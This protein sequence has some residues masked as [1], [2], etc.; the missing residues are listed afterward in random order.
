MS[1]YFHKQELSILRK[2]VDKAEKLIANK[3]YNK[4]E[5]INN[6]IVILEDY[7]RKHKLI[8]Y[9]GTAINNILPVED[10]FYNK[11]TEIP[12]YDFFSPN[13]IHDAKVLA[14]IYYKNGYTDVEAKAGVH[15]GTYKLFVNFIPIADITYQDPEIYDAINNEAIMVDGILYAPP[16]YL[17]MSMYL[18][19]SRPEG[20]VSRW[21]KILKRL[22][23]LNKH[24][25]MKNPK[26]NSLNFMRNFEHGY[27]KKTASIYTIVKDSLI[28]QGCV[29]FGGFAA[30]LYGKYMPKDEKKTL[31]KN[32]DFDVLAID[33][34]RS[35]IITKERLESE[36]IKNVKIFQRDSIGEIIPEHYEIKVAHETVAF[37][38]SPIACHS[39]NKIKLEHKTVKVAT[40]DTMLSFFLAFIYTDRPYYDRERILCMA[41]YLFYVQSKNRLKQKGLLRRFSISCYGEQDTIADIRAKKAQ[42]YRFLSKRK[43][44]PKF[45]KEYEKNFL[46]YSPEFDSRKTLKKKLYKKHKTYT[47]TDSDVNTEPD[48]NSVPDVNTEPDVNAELEISNY[49]EYIKDNNIKNVDTEVVEEIIEDVKKESKLVSKKEKRKKKN[50]TKKKNSFFNIH[51]PKEYWVLN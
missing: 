7:L 8:C 24:Y 28:D 46:K 23:L 38:Y 11:D 27:T 6:M 12:D 9:G 49:E 47:N 39:F 45:K 5:Q 1:D 2:A 26:C 30:T 33:P 21:E 51:V 18:E 17:R 37:I 15:E 13:A 16:N 10:Q 32:P 14:D 44:N 25:P 35:A 48:V 41:Q 19:L 22:I 4:P 43:Y 20:D 50:K 3:N 42:K 29:F 40:I 34:E 36:N 31:E